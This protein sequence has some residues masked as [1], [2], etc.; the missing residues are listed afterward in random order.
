MRDL[1]LPKAVVF[2]G[3][4]ALLVTPF[5]VT[6][7]LLFPF[8][9]GKAFFFRTIVEIIFVAWAVLALND[10]KYRPKK[11][12]LLIIFSLFVLALGVSTILSPN[13]YKSFWSNF[14]RMDGYVTLL[15]LFMLFVVMGSV[16]KE[17]AH[18]RR[19]WKGAAVASAVMCIYAFFQI[20]GKIAINQGG[21]RVDGTLGNA[22]YLAGYLLFSFFITLF[23]FFHEKKRGMQITYAALGIAQLAVLYF[24][25][26]RGAIL[27]VV[28]GLGLMALILAFKGKGKVRIAGISTVVV[29]AVAV[30]SFIALKDT[31]FVKESPVL[32]RFSTLSISDFKTQGRYFVWP[33]ALKGI[34]DKPVFGWGIESFNYVFNEYYDPRMYNQEP[35]FDRAHNMFLDWLVAGGIV[36]GGLFLTLCLT[37]LW[38]AFK[39]REDN[40]EFEGESAAILTALLAAYFFQGL[41]LFDNTVSYI[42][43]ISF[44]AYLHSR[45]NT[46]WQRVE[47]WDP[48]ISTR[49]TIPAVLSVVLVFTLYFGIWKPMRAGNH[50]I[51]GLT[52]VREQR[53][54]EAI[55]KL[56]EAISLHTLGDGE[57]REQLLSLASNVAS[58]SD[59]NI[60]REYLEMLNEELGKQIALTPDDLR[61]RLLYASILNRFGRADE[62]LVQL[63]KARE[64]S[65]T[66]QII[67]YEI[68]NAY[69]T[70][71]DTVRALEAAKTAYDLAPEN[72]DAQINLG[73]AYLYVGD[74]ARA[75]ELFRTVKG[76]MVFNDRIA[77]ALIEL[78][79]WQDVIEIFK[80]RVNAR[81]NDMNQYISLVS[82]Y[83]QA[84]QREN[85]IQV[86]TKIGELQP[87]YKPTADI[88]IEEIR[89]GRNP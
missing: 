60:Q 42:Y 31:T 58:L 66:K 54:G 34:S 72:E 10:E 44:L 25:A 29:I 67:Y 86:L 57:A 18:W 27:G 37:A 11:S 17:V 20:S 30:L 50:I 81:P 59:Q 73:V 53:I 89:Q 46:E 84:G 9:A 64:L 47:S 76:D 15:H 78:G 69:L 8:I 48:K 88:Y 55:S 43:F 68:M 7:S 28:G 35:W 85:A 36:G 4:F 14:E 79:R 24:T 82:A 26:T 39:E 52:A 87:S 83:L 2:T 61:Y 16:M 5:F 80:S 23:L 22:A 63:E 38:K 74:E 21:V 12:A 51:S 70:K 19:W 6:S 77:S 1:T 65:P 13:T 41:F 49:R 71:K 33:M 75:Q 32:S 56:Q 62:A 45:S 3:L 40:L